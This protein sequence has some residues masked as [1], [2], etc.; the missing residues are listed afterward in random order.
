MKCILKHVSFF[1]EKYLTVFSVMF[2][3]CKGI[4]F[5]NPLSELTK[6]LE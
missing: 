2:L 5:L 6:F 4:I 1:A 3:F